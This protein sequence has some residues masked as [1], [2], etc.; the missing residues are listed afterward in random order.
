MN[1]VLLITRINFFVTSH[2]KAIII[3]SKRHRYQSKSSSIQQYH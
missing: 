3:T 1:R 2:D